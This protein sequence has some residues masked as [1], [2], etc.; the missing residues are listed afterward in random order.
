MGKLKKSNGAARST[1]V[2]VYKQPKNIGPAK[3]KRSRSKSSVSNPGLAMYATAMKDPFHPG[4]VG[5]KV[6]D[7]L[8]LPS[9][10]YHAKTT[11]IAGVA[12]GKT[13]FSLW[14]APNPFVS[15]IDITRVNDSTQ[16]A[17]TSA[18]NMYKML[19]NPQVYGVTT[20]ALAAGI[21]REM[22]FVAGG[23][24][25]RTNQAWQ[26]AQGTLYWAYVPLVDNMPSWA[27]FDGLVADASAFDKW[28]G[29]PAAN[30]G[31]GAIQEMPGANSCS[32]IDL[33]NKDLI[34]PLVI[35]DTARFYDFKSTSTSTVFSSTYNVGNE[36][37]ETNLGAAGTPQARDSTSMAG[38]CALVVYSEGVPG[39][40]NSAVRMELIHHY[41]V[42]PTISGQSG[43]S[44][45]GIVPVPS[46]DSAPFH[47]TRDAVDQVVARINPT[48]APSFS[49]AINGLAEN[50]ANSLNIA[51]SV[52]RGAAKVGMA[53]SSMMQ[54]YR[55]NGNRRLG[56]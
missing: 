27:V 3:K 17:F 48:T 26:T 46:C 7:P 12:S 50:V 31:S 30:I 42:S 1:A 2:V 40:T 56:F 9:L 37:V 22:R 13:A 18:G 19:N 11:L 47:G 25:I 49:D 29:Q 41:E 43:S 54:A 45:T 38:A 53:Y 16:S 10:S 28:L 24:R 15:C 4:V 32:Y 34:L 33:Q 5:V 23:V 6:P 39:G 52:Y 35:Y 36:Y 44:T 55:G 20:P 8:S 21:A 51:S 14:F